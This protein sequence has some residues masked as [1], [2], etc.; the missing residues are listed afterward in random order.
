MDI[1]T[2]EKNPIVNLMHHHILYCILKKYQV[3]EVEDC[4]SENLQLL[5][6]IHWLLDKKT[7][8]MDLPSLSSKMRKA[9]T[10]ESNF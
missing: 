1:N 7:D 8:G 5:V 3:T 2:I 10:F 4:Y 6:P 9:G